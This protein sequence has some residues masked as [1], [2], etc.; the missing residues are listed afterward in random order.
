MFE[1]GRAPACGRNPFVGA[2]KPGK[3][4]SLSRAMMI[5]AMISC[6]LRLRTSFCVPVWQK[7]QVKVQPT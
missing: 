2:V 4:P 5:W 6:D 7:E 3:S 1:M